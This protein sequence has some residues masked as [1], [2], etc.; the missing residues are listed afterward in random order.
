MPKTQTLER[1]FVATGYIVKDAKTLLVFHKRLKLWLAPGGHVD[2]GETPEEAVL[3]EVREETGLGV[4]IV[5]ER[6]S[7]DPANGKVV[8]L[9]QP[10]HMQLED[11]PNPDGFHQHIDLI[12]FCR[13]L[14]GSVR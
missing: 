2:E 4:E 7:P 5:G 11:I 6:R 12:Y 14:S 1:H 10:R 3:R 8:Y 9:H 13:P